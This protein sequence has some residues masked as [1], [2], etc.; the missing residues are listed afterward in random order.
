MDEKKQVE[1]R[2]QE[3]RDLCTLVEGVWRDHPSLRLG[4]LLTNV[5]EIGDGVFYIEDENM[6]HQLMKYWKQHET[7][8][9]NE[10]DV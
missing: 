2:D 6:R 5:I 4:Q 3:I 7:E 8:T 10:S 9:P 1:K